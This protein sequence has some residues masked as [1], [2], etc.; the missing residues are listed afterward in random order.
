MLDNLKESKML[1][2]KTTIAVG[3]LGSLLSGCYVVPLNHTVPGSGGYSASGTAII[4]MAAIR[5]PFTARLY[6]ANQAASR[7]GG[8]SGIISN[9]EDGHGQFSFTIGG[10]AYQGEATRSRNSSK[11]LANASGNRGGFAR[12]DYTMSSATL[13]SGGCLFANGARY[14]MHISQ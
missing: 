12:C 11:G 2:L 9:P 3:M 10:E 6:P 8:A 5:A 4:P 1:N 7:L 13:G 14:D